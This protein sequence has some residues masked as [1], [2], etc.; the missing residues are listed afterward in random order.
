MSSTQA[1]KVRDNSAGSQ[2]R[3]NRFVRAILGS[4]FHRMM[5]GKLTVVHVTGRKSGTR[6]AV[7]TAYFDH[8]GQVLLASPGTWVRNLRSGE[9][10][11]LQLRGRRIRTR[12]EVAA[13]R[14]RAWEIASALLP[15]NPILRKFNKIDLDDAGQPRVDQF[16]A[17]L[18]RGVA[19]IALHPIDE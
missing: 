9:P 14:D 19:F 18:E 2:R 8:E 15:S 1:T 12:P 10:V 17:A 7:P 6:Y 5:S 3:F 16:D 13:D 4:P 11:E